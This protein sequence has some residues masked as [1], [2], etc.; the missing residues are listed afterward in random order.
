METVLI[1]FAHGSG[2]LGPRQREHAEQ[3]AGRSL[4][5]VYRH[6]PAIL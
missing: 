2:P 6:R 3:L 5:L 4:S 1:G